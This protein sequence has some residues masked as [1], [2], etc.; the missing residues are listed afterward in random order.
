[1]KL[2]GLSKMATSVAFDPV[3]Y[4][5]NTTAMGDCL[6]AVP[7]VKYAID[8]YHKNCDYRV[9]ASKHFREFF[10]F[11]PDAQFLVME[12]DTW[13]FDK[14]Y[15]VRRL[16]DVGEKGG[17]LCRLTPSKMTL[18][19]YASIGLLLELIP[20]NFHS[21]LPLP[22]VD[23]SRFGVD[24]S[25]SVV[26]VV[27]YR[28]VNR[29]I[30]SDEMMKISA[31]VYSQGLTPVYVGRTQDGHWKDRPPVSPFEAPGHGVDLRNQTSLLELATIMSK[32][33]AVCGVDSGPIHLAGTTST[34]II[35]GYTNVDWRHRIPKRMSGRTIV[36]EPDAKLEC[37]YCS[38]V[39]AKDFYNFLN[40]YYGH[41][42][43]VRS[44]TADKYINALVSVLEDGDTADINRQQS[45]RPRLSFDDAW[46]IVK[47]SLL[48][49]SKS[50]NLY[51]EILMVKD[52]EGD[53]AEIGVF[54]GSTSQLIRLVVP[55]RTLHC[56]DTF[57][58]I[59]KA[60][61]SIDKHKDGE[62][63]VSLEKVKAKLGN[64]DKIKYHVGLFPDSFKGNSAKF[65]FVHCDLDTYF[66]TKATLETM[67]PYLE[68]GGT[69]LFD[70]YRWIACPGVEKAV[71]EWLV[72][73]GSQC[74]FREYT[75]QC[76]VTKK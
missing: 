54:Q 44:L 61:P 27:S 4:S 25:K 67:F 66:G 72:I 68:T 45:V 42:N 6:A 17:N 21:Y 49:E 46:R 8:R 29:S 33:I 18:S 50:K 23:V 26:L 37:R 52:V 48:G 69:I 22:E 9:I 51:S 2:K 7:I 53:F 57:E 5:V 75:N 40:C 62:F 76:A 38:S 55:E 65:A 73:H 19:N 60:D 39:W 32:S 13:H 14:T 56:F 3:C 11:V 28:D 58:G 30:P 70:D 36:I 47:P 31:F 24:F 10:Y 74:H 1:M 43:C 71:H 16:N 34:T 59:A 20:S 63:A 41:N 15:S 12:D 64:S 35:A